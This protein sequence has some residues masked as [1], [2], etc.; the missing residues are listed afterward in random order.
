M[1]DGI[2]W[3][4]LS[5]KRQMKKTAFLVVLLCIPFLLAGVSRM[6]NKGGGGISIALY[7]GEELERDV[8]EALVELPGAFS[9]Y[10][11]ETA[12]EVKH[13]VETGKAECGYVFPADLREKLHKGKYRRSIDMW[14][15]PATVLDSMA[16]EVVFS[17]LMETY[18]P[19]ILDDYAREK[20]WDEERI[21]ELF[22]KYVTNGSTFSFRYESEGSKEAEENSLSM[23]FPARGIGAVFLFITGIFAVSSMAEDEKKGLFLCIPYGKKWWYTFLGTMAPVALGAVS[24]LISLYL[25]GAALT[26]VSG[27]VKETG[28]MAVYTAA[29]AAF[30]C[31][32]KRLVGRGEILAGTVPFFMIGSL[33]LC[34]VFIDAG[35]WIPQLGLLGRAFLPYY[36][37]SFFMP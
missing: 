23:T 24:V 20:S 11:C 35:A 18:G 13:D 37:L 36:Y 25:T 5:C 1:G 10:I 21:Q 30:A 15:S 28:A 31:L 12:E 26:G 7:A 19:E 14:S 32:L 6:G 22:Q 27:F 17:V 33:A 29:I 3:F 4:V 2:V 8:A 16:E 34:P 9:F